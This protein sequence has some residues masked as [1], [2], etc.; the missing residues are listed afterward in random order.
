MSLFV[1]VDSI[2]KS[3]KVIINLDEVVEIAPLIE[4][5]CAIFFADGAGMNSRS[6]IKVKDEYS[7][8]KQF[9]MQTVSADDISKKVKSLK[10]Q[11]LEIPKL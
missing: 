8:F 9:V 3:C 7:L 4:G 11:A 10:V 6:A 2:D 5:G 1:E